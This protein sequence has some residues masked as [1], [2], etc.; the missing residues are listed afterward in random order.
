VQGRIFSLPV[1]KKKLGAY[2]RVPLVL[3]FERAGEVK[4]EV[5]VEEREEP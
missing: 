5:M 2:D 3:R 4:I 1:L